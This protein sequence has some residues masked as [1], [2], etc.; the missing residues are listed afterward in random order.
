MT[1]LLFGCVALGK[2]L[3]L[4][5][6]HFHI[7]KWIKIYDYIN[8]PWRVAL[9]IGEKVCKAQGFPGGSVVKNLPAQQEM[10]ILSLGQED[11]LEEG[12]ATYSS[13]LAWEIPWTAEPGGLQSIELQSL[14]RLSNKTI[15]NAKHQEQTA[16]ATTPVSSLVSFLSLFWCYAFTEHLLWA[17]Q[18]PRHERQKSVTHE[19]WLRGTDS[20]VR[21]VTGTQ[22]ALRQTEGQKADPREQR[23]GKLYWLEWTKEASWRKW[24]GLR[25]SIG[26]II[27]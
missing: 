27:I 20:Q 13:I 3:N 7:W 23:R 5:E 24:P 6:L 4:S 18:S 26:C 21:A 25:F 2:S 11:P 17:R 12:M 22:P 14:T 8:L 1:L 19:P 16:T 10:Q 15:T 9:G